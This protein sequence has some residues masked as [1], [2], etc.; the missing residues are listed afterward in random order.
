[1]TG[2][3][4]GWEG[5]G[6][7]LEKC[8]A[9]TLKSTFINV[10]FLI[11]IINQLRHMSTLLGRQEKNHSTLIADT[12]DG[13]MWWC[14]GQE[15][16]LRVNSRIKISDFFCHRKLLAIRPLPIDSQ[17]TEPYAMSYLS[18]T[19]DQDCFWGQEPL[20][21]FVWLS[22]KVTNTIKMLLF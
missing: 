20:G 11:Q 14:F 12:Q 22:S 2:Q 21:Y 8:I 1:M 9:Y 19:K 3:G 7:G 6:V 4:L 18:E 15:S 5:G 17:P 10:L 13:R 16:V